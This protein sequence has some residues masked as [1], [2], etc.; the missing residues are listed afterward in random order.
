MSYVIV[1]FKKIP[2]L[3]SLLL[4]GIL[5]GSGAEPEAGNWYHNMNRNWTQMTMLFSLNLK[6]DLTWTKSRKFLSYSSS[7]KTAQ[8]P[9]LALS[10]FWSHLMFCSVFPTKQGDRSKS[11]VKSLSSWWGDGCLT[12]TH[13]IFA[14]EKSNKDILLKLIILNVK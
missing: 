10:E 5:S 1:F 8:R 2:A 13:S 4:H 12:H 14:S 6:L 11:F 9:S 7:P 3:V